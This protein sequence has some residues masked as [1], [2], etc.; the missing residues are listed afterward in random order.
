MSN[1]SYTVTQES[2]A[3]FVD[4]QVRVVKKGAPNFVAL[5]KAILEEDWASL[6]HH[7]SAATSLTKWAKGRFKIDGDNLLYDGALVSPDITSRISEMATN[8]EDPTSLFNFWERLQGNPSHRSVQQLFSFLKNIGIP[9]TVDGCFLA[10]KSV[11]GDFKDC[12]TGTID[13]SVGKVVMMPRNQISDDPDLACHVGLHV[14]ALEYAK[15]FS[16]ERIVICKVDPQDVVCVPH[17]CSQQKLRACKYTVVGLHDD[18]Y[19]PSTTIADDEWNT[20]AEYLDGGLSADYWGDEL[21]ESYGDFSEWDED[22]V[23]EE[24]NGITTDVG[25]S[26][27]EPTIVRLKSAATTKSRLNRWLRLDSMDKYDLMEE[28]FDE[29]RSYA[30]QGLH[31]VGASRIRGGKLELVNAIV[32]GRDGGKSS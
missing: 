26:V 11:R 32:R 31:I 10:Y 3:V 7:L 14:G 21:D 25:S 15:G 17:D 20:G 30:S 24:K 6:P 12:H 18:G 13:N 4:G 1:I 27:N 9:L 29:L 23:T 5:R 28:P 16:G 2:V 19:M 22:E 8:G